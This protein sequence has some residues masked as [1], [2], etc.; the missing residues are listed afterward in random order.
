[1]ASLGA[2]RYDTFLAPS[3]KPALKNGGGDSLLKYPELFWKL[4]QV[5]EQI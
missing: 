2:F 5:Q 4:V 1:M 3:E